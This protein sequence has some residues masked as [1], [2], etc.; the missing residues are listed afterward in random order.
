[1]QADFVRECVTPLDT[2]KTLS[3]VIDPH[4]AEVESFAYE[5]RSSDGTKVIE[6]KKTRNLTEDENI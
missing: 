5:I 3:F 1:M 2:T 6:N 4:E